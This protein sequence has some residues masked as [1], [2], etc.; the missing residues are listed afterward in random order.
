MNTTTQQ[1]HETPRQA[2]PLKP[3]VR[4]AITPK[5]IKPKVRGKSDFFS[6]QLYRW[7]KK[8]PARLQIFKGTRNSAT[9]IDREKPQLYIGVMT[10]DH[11]FHGAQLRYI[12]CVG[13]KIEAWAYGPNFDTENWENITDQFWNDYMKIGTC[14]IHGDLWHDW[15]TEGDK[16][17]CTRCGATEHKQT[18]TFTKEVWRAP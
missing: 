1:N 9:G 10:D 7:V 2:V 14:A 18:E 11:W 15:N 13:R 17:T 8:Y 5:L 3:I 12:C 4:D 16:R 6:W